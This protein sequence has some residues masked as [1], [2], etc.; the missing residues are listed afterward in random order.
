MSLSCISL[1]LLRYDPYQLH[2]YSSSKDHQG[3]G[4][5][6]LQIISVNTSVNVIRLPK[7]HVLLEKSFRL[8]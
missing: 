4:Q 6:I 1:Q 7:K 2:P 8:I 3:H 5:I